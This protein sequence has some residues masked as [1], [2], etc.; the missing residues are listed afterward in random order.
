[1]RTIAV[2]ITVIAA[3][4][5]SPG[6]GTQSEERFHDLTYGFSVAVPNFPKETDAG[7]TV[8]PVVFGGPLRDGKAPSCNV[9]IQNVGTL[10]NFRIQ[11]LGQLKALGL[12]LES[13]SRRQVS[14]K[15]ALLFV[16]SGHDL[17]VFS[18]AVQVDQSIDL[19]TCV[20]PLN[21]FTA[22]EKTFRRV[23]DS[24]SVN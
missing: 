3:L 10:S 5:A 7:V 9:Q 1:M 15:D 2:A 12:S 14:K 20:A 4:V 17:K 16:S 8:T 24:F 6:S 18:L 11:S 13:E 19:V 22:N 21:Q 23:I